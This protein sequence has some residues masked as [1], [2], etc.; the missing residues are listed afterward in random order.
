MA[1]NTAAQ[2]REF[3][4]SVIHYLAGCDCETTFSRP[5]HIGWRGYGY[6]FIRSAGSKGKVDLVAV[7]GEIYGPPLLFI[8]CKISNP[9]ISPAER[10]GLTDLSRRA[11]ATPLVAYR[12]KDITTGRL[13]PHFRLLTGTGPRD[14]APWEPGEDES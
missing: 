13:R 8:Q 5:R 10:E 3:E 12:A 9:L 7:W 2:G 1:R 14:W 11:D 6:D 4:H